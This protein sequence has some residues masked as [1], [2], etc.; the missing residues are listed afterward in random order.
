MSTADQ[1]VASP[2]PPSD[3][4]DAI[5]RSRAKTI[6]VEANAGAAKTTT[7]AFRIRWAIELNVP[8]EAIQVLTFT[9]P[10]CEAMR[11]A[12]ATVGVPPALVRRIKIQ[13]FDAF[14]ATVLRSIEPRLPPIKNTPEDVAPV[15]AQAMHSVDLGADSG[16]VERF[17]N[18]SNWL[19]GTL[20]LNEATWNG[21]HIDEDWAEN[22]GIEFS[23]VQL[24][25]A[26]ENLRYPIADGIDMP[27]FRWTFDAT[28]DLAR[29][30]A[31]PEPM[32][33]LDEIPAWPRTIRLLMVDE[34]HDTNRAMYVILKTLLDTNP[35]YFCGVG[36]VDQVIHSQSGADHQ[37]MG[38]HVSFGKREVARYPLTATRRFSKALAAASGRLAHKPYASE[39]SHPTQI[40]VQTYNLDQGSSCVDVLTAALRD[41][42]QQ[43]QMADVAILLRHAWQ[44]IDIEN[45]LVNAGMPYQTKGFVSYLQQPEVLLIRA[46]LAVAT[47]QYEQLNAAATRA[48]VV[49]ALVF[50]CGVQLDH[51]Q[52]EAETQ[53]ERLTSAIAAIDQSKESLAAFIEYQI[54]QKT[55]PALAQR[56]RSAIDIAQTAGERA[57][58]FDDFLDALDIQTWIKRV[59]IERQR[60]AD[61]LKYFEGL[62]RAA[63]LF[64]TAGQFFD[65][66]GTLETKHAPTNSQQKNAM[67][68]A[69][70][71]RNTLTLAIIPAVKGLEFE[72]VVMPYLDRGAFPFDG[73]QRPQDERNL[74]YV[75]ITRARSALT[76]ICAEDHPSEFVA[77]LSPLPT[78]RT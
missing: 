78:A 37:Y 76:V 69:S 44:S 68:A 64:K 49:K 11:I 36:D 31:D 39:S 20:A 74:F 57:G 60:R 32:T 21:E 33:Y 7:L 38:P 62:K 1:L 61:A 15:V 53:D 8:P 51:D 4:Q 72:H 66:M 54:L 59:F 2:F 9:E 47:G 27:H 42:K 28:Y 13:T 63:R 24:F 35:C 19:K 70:A 43:A 26:Y 34:M 16:F 75:G 18:T 77:H 71:K 41:W 58:W 3:E 22:N 30:L 14:S 55:A 25:R 17:L 10:A 52:S 73:T 29:Q 40:K 50:F 5:Q 46:L 12:L 65:N 56:M 23:H 48:Q 67:R 45:A 6:I